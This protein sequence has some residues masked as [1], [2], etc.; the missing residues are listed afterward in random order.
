MT[1][2]QERIEVK[3]DNMI[4]LSKILKEDKAEL[5]TLP[6]GDDDLSKC[7]KLRDILKNK[8]LTVNV[9]EGLTNLPYVQ[10]LLDELDKASTVISKLES[11]YENNQESDM[12]EKLGIIDHHLVMMYNC[13]DTIVT[14]FE[15]YQHLK[16]N[17][18][19]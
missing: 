6:Q 19:L 10:K 18:N 14:A 9:E 4:K 3:V 17:M 8:F 7:E 12:F 5:Q 16:Q 13:L 11:K 15:K 1:K 2:N